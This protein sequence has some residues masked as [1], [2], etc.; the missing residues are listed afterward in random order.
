MGLE[1]DLPAFDAILIYE[2]TDHL[3]IICIIKIDFMTTCTVSH[4]INVFSDKT[5]RENDP[6]DFCVR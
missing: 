2:P 6:D 3:A 4:A 5:C 1:V